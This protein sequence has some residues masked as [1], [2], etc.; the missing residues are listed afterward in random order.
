VSL[1]Q[2]LWLWL[3]CLVFSCLFLSCLATASKTLSYLSS[4]EPIHPYPCCHPSLNNFGTKQKGLSPLTP[5]LGIL[6]LQIYTIVSTTTTTKDRPQNRARGGRKSTIMPGKDE[7]D[8]L[9]LS[10]AKS[11]MVRRR[12]TATSGAVVIFRISVGSCQD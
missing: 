8:R 1:A 5:T 3:S 10:I 6:L 2:R 12:S 7:A 4:T 11:R 9:G